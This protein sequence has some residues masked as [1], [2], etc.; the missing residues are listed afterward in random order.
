MKVLFVNSCIRKNSRTLILCRKYLEKFRTDDIKEINVQNYGLKP[1]DEKMLEKRNN[2][3]TDGDFSDCEYDLAKEFALSDLIVIGAPF[4]DNSFPAVLKIYLEHI[5]V[6]GITFGYDSSGKPL[7]LCK[8]EKLV[9]ITT[10]GGYISQRNSCKLLLE[11][12]CDMFG[13]DKLEFISAQ[14]LDIV[15]NNPDEIIKIT[16]Q[17]I[18]DEDF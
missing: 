7:S 1:F 11:D 13:I 10:S 14:G 6:N 15:G 8:A 17:K 16:E 12:M 2:D 18:T 5:C 4:W 3:I 9:Y